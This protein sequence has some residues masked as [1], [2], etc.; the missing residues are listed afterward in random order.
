MS[1]LTDSSVLSD[2][3]GLYAENKVSVMYFI[4]QRIKPILIVATEYCFR[5]LFIFTQERTKNIQTLC[6][7]I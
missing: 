1:T 5:H 2:V 3:T 6:Y 4:Y 7:K